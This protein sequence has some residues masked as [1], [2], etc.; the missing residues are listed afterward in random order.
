MDGWIAGKEEGGRIQ[1]GCR[2]YWTWNGH[3]SIAKISKEKQRRGVEGKSKEKRRRR[4]R[5]EKKRK[6]R[7]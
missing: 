6:F 2:E 3:N 7:P 5:K 1:R 4:E